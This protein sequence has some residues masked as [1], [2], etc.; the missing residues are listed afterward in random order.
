MLAEHMRTV[1]KT[2]VNPP[3]KLFD[4]RAGGLSRTSIDRPVKTEATLNPPSYT[5]GE[6]DSLACHKCE[7]E[8]SDVHSF[9]VGIFKIQDRFNIKWI[10]LFLIIIG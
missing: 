5:R 3:K 6:R 9:E 1:H 2:T 10:S 7:K 4:S 8:F